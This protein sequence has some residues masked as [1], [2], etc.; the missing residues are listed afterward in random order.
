MSSA[1]IVITI[2]QAR[3]FAAASQGTIWQLRL[4]H[5]RRRQRRLPARQ[6]LIAQSGNN[7]PAARG[8]RQG[9]LLLDQHPGGLP[10]HH[11][12]PAHRLVLQDRTRRA[13]RRA[14]DP[15]RARPRARRLLV[16]QGWSWDEVLPI[17]KSIEDYEGGATDGYGAGG[18]V[19]VENPRVRWDIIDAWRA[20]AAE[21][22]IPPVRAFNGGDNF[23]C[24]YFQMNQ[25]RGRRWSATN[26][27][28][29][30]VHHRRNLTVLTDA[31]VLKLNFHGRDCVGLEFLHDEKTYQ[32]KTKQETILA[33]GAIGSPQLLQL[34]GVGPRE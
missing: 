4:C 23:G 29:R 20:A 33:A 10:V 17:F 9:R 32:V 8:R 15:L 3:A 2:P 5:R 25:K 12:Q 1:S 34:S 14:L 30:P 16:D 6:S 11:R 21:C 13:P 31:S 22:G 27:F 18:E 19:R 28:L 26:A 24:A 7:R